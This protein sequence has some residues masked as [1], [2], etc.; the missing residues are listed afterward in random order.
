MHALDPEWMLRRAERVLAPP[1]RRVR[2]LWLKP[3]N[4]HAHTSALCQ[5]ILLLL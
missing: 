2:P 5:P 3:S 4:S 1:E